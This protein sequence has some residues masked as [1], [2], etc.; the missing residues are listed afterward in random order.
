MLNPFKVYALAADARRAEA[1]LRPHFYGGN[2]SLAT[3]AHNAVATVE[4]RE[5]MCRQ[6]FAR[7]TEL[8]GA[9]EASTAKIARMTSGLKRGTTPKVSA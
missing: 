6:Y 1:I 9:L 4:D 5:A 8:E 2:W 3:M 7:V